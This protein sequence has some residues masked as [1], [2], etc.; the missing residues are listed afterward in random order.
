[1]ENASIYKQSLGFRDSHNSSNGGSSKNIT[2]EHFV[3][4]LV[5][6]VFFFVLLLLLLAVV[7]LMCIALLVL[8]HFILFSFLST[9]TRHL[10][11]FYTIS[12]YLKCIIYYYICIH[13]SLYVVWSQPVFFTTMFCSALTFLRCKILLFLIFCL[14]FVWRHLHICLTV[15]VHSKSFVEVCACVQCFFCLFLFAA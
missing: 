7:L 3:H 13:I 1:M 15:N 8:F 5:V 6:F 4:K 9:R 10:E 11:K 14:Y 12:F 2:T